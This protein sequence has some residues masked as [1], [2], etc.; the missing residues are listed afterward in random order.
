VGPLTQIRQ[1]LPLQ[2]V[3][4]PQS[5]ARRLLLEIHQPAVLH[6]HQIL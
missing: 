6:H 5:L 2:L 3:A 1:Q 4:R